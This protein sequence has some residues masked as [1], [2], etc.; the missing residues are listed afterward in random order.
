MAAAVQKAARELAPKMLDVAS[1]FTDGRETIIFDA[2]AAPAP[3]AE[4]LELV[5]W[6]DHIDEFPSFALEVDGQPEPGGQR[7]CAPRLEPGIVL[8][9]EDRELYVVA[10]SPG[11]AR[12]VDVVA[13]R[14]RA[15]RRESALDKLFPSREDTDGL[16]QEGV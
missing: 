8:R 10:T 3:T 12:A 2:L 14:G 9:H 4:V 11:L 16:D 5:P 1:V 15:S 7:W 6:A 13:V